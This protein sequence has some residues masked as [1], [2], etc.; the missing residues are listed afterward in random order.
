LQA[1]PTHFISSKVLFFFNFADSMQKLLL[2]SLQLFKA[3]NNFLTE[4]YL[5][6]KVTNPLEG[7][8]AIKSQLL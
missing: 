8:A 5:N 1:D 6:I 3:S 2:Q 7:E 4:F